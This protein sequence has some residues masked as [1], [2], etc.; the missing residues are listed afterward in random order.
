MRQREREGEGEGEPSLLDEGEMEREDIQPPRAKDRT[1]SGKAA[2]TGKEG[3]RQGA[4]R[5]AGA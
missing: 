5:Q 1:G 3:C 2:S 4:G